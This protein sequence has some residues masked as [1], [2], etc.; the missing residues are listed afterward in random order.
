MGLSAGQGILIVRARYTSFVSLIV[1]VFCLQFLAACESP[2]ESY[3]QAKALADSVGGPKTFLSNTTVN[4]YE[5]RHGNQYEYLAA[6]GTTALLYPGNIAPV[7]GFWQIRG[8]GE[9]GTE[10]CFLYGA[11]TYNPV[12]KERGGAWEC[13]GFIE[14]LYSAQEIYE[15][16]VFGTRSITSFGT[17][18]PT[19][20]KFQPISIAVTA[21]GQK[22]PKGPNKAL[23][24]D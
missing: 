14:Y 12:T 5:Q 6:D 18:F 15:G 20:R 4:T 23:S 24:K 16:D 7:R 13:R 19:W 1:S 2:H 21:T 8:T 22:S 10:M 9:F 11:N 17:P 3:P